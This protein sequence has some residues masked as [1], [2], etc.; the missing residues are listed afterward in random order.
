MLQSLDAIGS[1]PAALRLRGVSKSFAGNLAVAAEELPSGQALVIAAN[2]ALP[3]DHH[4]AGVV[5]D[6]PAGRPLRPLPLG[7][8]NVETIA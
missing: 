5:I 4:Q 2:V 1:A 8:V 6:L 3:I 7:G